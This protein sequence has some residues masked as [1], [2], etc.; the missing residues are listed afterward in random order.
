MDHSKSTEEKDKG[1]DKKK[2]EEKK[3][4]PS[5]GT[6]DKGSAKKV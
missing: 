6:S 1:D 5:P 2:T 4:E 3:K